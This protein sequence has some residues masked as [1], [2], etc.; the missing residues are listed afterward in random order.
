MRRVWGA[1]EGGKVR[2][3]GGCRWARDGMG[4]RWAVLRACVRKCVCVWQAISGEGMAWRGV[5]RGD[6]GPG[7]ARAKVPGNR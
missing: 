2:L 3:C 7:L 1:W 6:G 4:G 5:R